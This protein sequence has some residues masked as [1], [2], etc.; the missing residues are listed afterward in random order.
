LEGAKEMAGIEFRA[1]VISMQFEL[2]IKL[3]E[4]TH[5]CEPRVRDL[6]VLRLSNFA[7]STDM[8]SGPSEHS[9]VECT[10]KIKPQLNSASDER[11]G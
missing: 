4:Q 2:S 7:Q 3:E 8:R 5:T 1:K 9:F 10:I 11:L 6:I